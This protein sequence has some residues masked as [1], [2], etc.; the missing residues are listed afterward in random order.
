[1][2]PLSKIQFLDKLASVR[3]IRT[4]VNRWHRERSIDQIDTERELRHCEEELDSLIATVREMDWPEVKPV[5]VSRPA[6]C[7]TCFQGH[8]PCAW[9]TRETDESL[10][11]EVSKS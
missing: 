6:D 7:C 8:A 1:M 3:R 4:L 9:C 11:E 2:K 10:E 5:Y